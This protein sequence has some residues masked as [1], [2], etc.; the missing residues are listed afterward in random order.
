MK[1]QLETNRRGKEAYVEEKDLLN[2]ILCI[3]RPIPDSLQQYQ[4]FAKQ[5][6]K[7]SS[8]I[9]SIAQSLATVFKGRFS[10]KRYRSVVRDPSPSDRPKNDEDQ[11]QSLSQFSQQLAVT[12][13]KIANVLR[14]FAENNQ[15]VD[16]PE[17]DRCPE[18]LTQYEPTTL[19]EMPPSENV[20]EPPIVILKYPS[21]ASK[22]VKL[23]SKQ[24]P[25]NSKS[26]KRAPA[27]I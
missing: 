9:L 23:C 16:V 13:T 19:P 22:T 8:E 11:L 15:N 2:L 24:L 12:S 10:Q 21:K 4:D 1:Q 17:H 3:K 25:K 7:L 5:T 18:L 26:L 6:S 14:A 27:P 20:I